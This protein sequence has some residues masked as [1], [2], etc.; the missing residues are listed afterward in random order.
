MNRRL[1]GGENVQVGRQRMSLVQIVSVFPLPAEGLAFLD[2]EAACIDIPAFEKL[3]M[4]LGEV[5]ADHG[6]KADI[7]EITG[8]G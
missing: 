3:D 5:I 6:N 4:F 7:R 2:F 1:K 8:R